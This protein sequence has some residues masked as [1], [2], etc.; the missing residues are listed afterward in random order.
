MGLMRS[1]AAVT[2]PWNL[3][4][5]G[6]P[7][8][9]VKHT[10]THSQHT[11]NISPVFFASAIS[12]YPVQYQTIFHITFRD[13]NH[14]KPYHPI[15]NILFFPWA[16]L[17]SWNEAR[18]ENSPAASPTSRIGLNI[19]GLEVE[20]FRQEKCAGLAAIMVPRRVSVG[21]GR[22]GNRDLSLIDKKH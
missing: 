9:T 11:R 7:Y 3:D 10:H 6:E 14:L 17:N 1:A 18:V 5:Y 20:L 4:A 22:D 8:H 19:L 2:N 15:F 13:L 12:Q 21:G 16:S